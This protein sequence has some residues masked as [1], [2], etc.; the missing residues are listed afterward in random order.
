MPRF[1]RSSDPTVSMITSGGT[2]SQ[3]DC[4]LFTADPA[5]APL[6]ITFRSNQNEGFLDTY[7]VYMYKG[8]G[9]PFPIERVSGGQF[10]GSYAHGDNLI[11]NSFRGTLDDPTYGSPTPNGVTVDVRPQGGGNWLT[12]AQTFCAFSI[13][14]SASVRITDGQTVFGPYYSGPI[15]IGIQKA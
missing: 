2:V 10:T 15:L 4:A 8:A 6:E 7:T 1:V 3:G 11:C 9:N 14:L 5:N 13:N 12:N